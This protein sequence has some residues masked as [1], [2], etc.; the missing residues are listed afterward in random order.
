MS[1]RT[2]VPSDLCTFGLMSIRTYVLSDQC[3]VGPMS[4][5][6]MSVG[7]MS[8]GPMSVG[9]MSVYRVSNI[10]GFPVFGFCS[11]RRFFAE[12]VRLVHCKATCTVLRHQAMSPSCLMFAYCR[13]TSKTSKRIQSLWKH[14]K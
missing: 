10:G 7:P 6:P 1:H 12:K 8:V 11:M 3:P 13:V 14:V 9:P 5:G 4:F 2:Y